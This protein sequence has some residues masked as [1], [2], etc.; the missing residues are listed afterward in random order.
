MADAHDGDS[1]GGQLVSLTRGAGQAEPDGALILLHGRGVDH[2]DLYPLLDQL[3]PE[4]RLHGIVPGAP[5]VDP[6]S[7]G[8]HW[9]VVEVVGQPETES[10]LAGAGALADFCD[11]LLADH[12]I[13]WG[14]AV[15]G[16]FSQGGA[17]AL[18]TAMRSGGPAPAGVLVMSSFL[19]SVAGWPMDLAAKAE[20][21]VWISHGSADPIIPVDFGRNAK[22]TLEGAGLTVTYNESAV[23]HGIDPALLPPLQDWLAAAIPPAG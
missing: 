12:G 5:I 20:V 14:R 1:Q 6:G 2:H 21:P 10:F 13:D 8:R 19:P 22:A 7:G 11:G 3:D 17:M 9:Y 23:G 4:R 18:A 15:I 16:G